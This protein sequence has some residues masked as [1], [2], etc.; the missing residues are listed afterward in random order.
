MS[1]GE[2][3]FRLAALM[4]WLICAKETHTTSNPPHGADGR[5]TDTEPKQSSHWEGGMG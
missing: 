5:P 2:I 1:G 3:G 4:S